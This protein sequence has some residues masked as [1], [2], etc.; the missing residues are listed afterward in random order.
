M[1]KLSKRLLSILLSLVMV[2]TAVPAFAVTAQ[3]AAT[4][5]ADDKL[6]FAYFC[7]DDT[8]SFTV[9]Q[10][11]RL[12]VSED[13]INFSPLNGNMP[14]LDNTQGSSINF[15]SMVGKFGH[16]G[17]ARDPFI[18]N[19]RDANG[20]ITAGYYV[21]AT[22]LCVTSTAHSYN[23]QKI[24]VW[25]ISDL[26][27]IANV[28]PKVIDTTG[29]FSEQ[30]TMQNSDDAIAW[31]PE[32][33]WCNEMK[34][35]AL[36]WSGPFYTNSRI[37]VAFTT[38]FQTFRTS[39]G[40]TIDGIN[41]FAE[42]LYSVSGGYTIDANINYENGKYY[43]V[44]KREDKANKGKI[45]FAHAET[46]MGLKN[47]AATLFYDSVNTGDP[48]G[49]EGP[50]VYKRPDGHWVLIADEYVKKTCSFAMYDL[51]TSLEDGLVNKG[52]E[53]D[54]RKDVVSTNINSVYPRH[55]GMALISNDEYNALNQAYA[56][57]TP[58]S[59]GQLV[60]QYFT[61]SNVAEDATGHGYT[62]S[63]YNGLS[64]ANGIGGRDN[65][66]FF[67]NGSTNSSSTGVAKYASVGTGQMNTGDHTF[68]SKDGFTFMW[69]AYDLGTSGGYDAYA[70]LYN[71]S[72]YTGTVGNCD[73]NESNW[74]QNGYKLSYVT[75]QLSGGISN[76]VTTSAGIQRNDGSSPATG[77][78][79]SYRAVYG[80]N[81]M[82]V[83]RDNVK[84]LSYALDGINEDWVS[85]LFGTNGRINIGASLFA[86][87]KLFN[88]YISN[89]RIYNTSNQQNVAR[90][91][92][93][94]KYPSVPITPGQGLQN[95]QKMMGEFE[96]RMNSDTIF[97]NV[98]PAYEKYVAAQAAIDKACETGDGSKLTTAAYDLQLAMDGMSEWT[99]PDT[100]KG[101]A[102][103]KF[104]EGNVSSNYYSNLLY[105]VPTGNYSQYQFEH[106][107]TDSIVYYQIS[108]NQTVVLHDGS[109]KTVIPVMFQSVVNAKNK[110]RCNYAVFPTTGAGSEDNLTDFYLEKNWTSEDA[111]TSDNNTGWNFANKIAGT[112]YYVGYANN[113]IQSGK[114][115]SA[116]GWTGWG[117]SYRF[118]YANTMLY[119][120][121]TQFV[122]DTTGKY[123]RKY[124][125]WWCMAD[126]ASG[127][128]SFDGL[129]RITQ[130]IGDN[131]AIYVVNYKALL[132]A[133][134]AAQKGVENYRQGGWSDA[135][136]KAIED[137][138]AYNPNTAAT[139]AGSAADVVSKFNQDVSEHISYIE[140]AQKTPD[141]KN[142]TITHA[143]TSFNWVTDT[144]P[145]CEGKGN[146]I[147]TCVFCGKKQNRALSPIGHEYRFDKA[148]SQYVC[149]HDAGHTKTVDL[150][151]YDET[152]ILSGLVDKSAYKDS[153]AIDTAKMALDGVIDA[154]ADDDKPQNTIDAA[155]TS[156]IT[157]INS[158]NTE[159]AQ[160]KTYNVKFYVNIDGE[161]NLISDSNVP[162]G[163]VV[164]LD[165][166]ATGLVGGVEC[167]SW[168]V[169]T[170]GTERTFSQ[171]GNTRTLL[172]Q[173]DTVVT[174]YCSTTDRVAKIYNPYNAVLYTVALQVGDTITAWE[175]EVTVTH[176]GTQTTYIVGSMPYMVVTGF[177]LDGQEFREEYTVTADT[178]Q[179]NI[180]PIVD[181]SSAGTYTV[182]LDGNPVATNV[183]Y[184]TMVTVNSNSSKPYAIAIKLGDGQY[185]IAAYG[186]TYSFYANRS[187]DFCTV[188]KSGTAYT[189]EGSTVTDKTLIYKLNN[190]LPDVYSGHA[191]TD[192]ANRVTTFNA[193]TVG[194][195][196]NSIVILEAGTIYTTGTATE[197]TFVLGA[198]GVNQVVAKN[199]VNPGNQ[200]SLSIG[201]GKGKGVKTRA[202]VRYSYTKSTGETVEAITYGNVCVLA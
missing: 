129:Q 32:V 89:F 194:C 14:L 113:H 112:K 57:Y 168:T 48:N 60:A 187:V 16:T 183:A 109:T 190:R 124:N 10:K 62:L 167:Y 171:P 121:N 142:K 96:K 7:G 93:L 43:M 153:A 31:A 20:N 143:D 156:M 68:T 123:S 139:N 92:Y 71:L 186:G 159:D 13:G 63:T 185:A 191:V 175:N 126:E 15:N 107:Y 157:A 56:G 40:A 5:S 65:V 70:N 196:S 19:K 73:Y 94:I 101:T 72:T 50:E 41:T 201:N 29:M 83:Y 45:Y 115:M 137:A 98:K 49:L 35:Y 144:L 64:T 138:M 95:V 119:N 163:K 78:W 110:K 180:K 105:S 11:I 91:D 26:S 103:P 132:D 44:F 58:S 147:G 61:T 102:V 54:H 131:C 67:N 104:Q 162:Y 145:T 12:A 1:N 172:V 8:T 55:G 127:K 125:L 135:F 193:I 116:G 22:D 178:T 34:A 198:E 117:W 200:Y 136:F 39:T 146:E 21:V 47:C 158:N 111:S 33:V 118:T 84:V 42:T 160:K 202:Y 170:G 161:S 184:D 169:S 150:T 37:N 85:D 133:I 9:N 30:G 27:N 77:G 179:V 59:P 151:V 75:S 52:G 155:I 149:Q 199:I 182:T 197:D 122:A 176:S 3:A 4:G 66:A 189:I 100:Y 165:A 80:R 195:N 88:G 82:V 148:G 166:N 174:A 140:T 106:S 181:K 108:N 86:N 6:L 53:Y 24:M 25:D 120:Q 141:D 36:V 128:S 2:I 79:H 192:G 17:G 74:P 99:M 76:G 90:I 51:G 188:T 134:K 46:L 154:A 97:T 81:G 164:T 38:D 173:A 18:I 114:E 69:D 130:Q 28:K 177:M 87:D 152:Q 23:N